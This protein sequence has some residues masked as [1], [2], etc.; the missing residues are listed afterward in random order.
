M[1]LY[2]LMMLED[3]ALGHH[4]CRMQLIA[5]LLIVVIDDLVIHLEDLTL[6][7]VLLGV[8]GRFHLLDEGADVGGGTQLGGY[9][10]NLWGGTSRW[11]KRVWPGGGKGTIRVGKLYYK[12]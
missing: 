2:R 1:I 3:M 8:A 12:A 5:Y 4:G 10:L 7:T 9:V 11:S 6:Q